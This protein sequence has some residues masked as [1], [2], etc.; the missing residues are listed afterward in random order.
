MNF[1]IAATAKATLKVLVYVWAE[2]RTLHMIH[3][4]R[5]S[6]LSDVSQ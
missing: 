5:G 1:K 6:Y 3:F 2:A 4:I